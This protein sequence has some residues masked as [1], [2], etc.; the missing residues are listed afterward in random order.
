MNLDDARREMTNKE[1]FER[2]ERSRQRFQKAVQGVLLALGMPVV[3]TAVPDASVSEVGEAL[4][5]QALTQ[6]FKGE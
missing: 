5:E 6:V 3:L 4:L 2:L 1:A